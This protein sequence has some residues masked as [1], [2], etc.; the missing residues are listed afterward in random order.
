MGVVRGRV[1]SYAWQVRIL[2]DHSRDT[3][4]KENQSQSQLVT[5]LEFQVAPN[6]KP[7]K[8]KPSQPQRTQ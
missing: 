4:L 8:K 7:Q 5:A 6:S 1:V 2:E 3:P